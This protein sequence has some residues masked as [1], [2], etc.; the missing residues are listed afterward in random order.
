MSIY[1]IAGDMLQPFVG[2]KTWCNGVSGNEPADHR[3]AVPGAVVVEAGFGV[4]GLAGELVGGIGCAGVASGLA[5]KVVVVC[6]I[7]GAVRGVGCLVEAG[8]PEDLK[9]ALVSVPVV[10]PAETQRPAQPG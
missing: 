1:P 6:F 8:V 5:V 2:R 4:E 9:T 3:V 7:D 10:L